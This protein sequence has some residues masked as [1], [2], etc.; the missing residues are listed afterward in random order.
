M[1]SP[2]DSKTYNNTEEALAAIHP[3]P[4]L[5]SSVVLSGNAIETGDRVFEERQMR[6]T[7]SEQHEEN[8]QDH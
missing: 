4:L 5:F 1:I 3:V 8:T 6:W 2:L 7:E